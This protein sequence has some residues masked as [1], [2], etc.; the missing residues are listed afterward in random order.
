MTGIRRF[1]AP[2][3]VF[4]VLGAACT[5]GGKT[6]AASGTARP[7]T[8]TPTPVVPVSAEPGVFVYQNAGLT[9]TLHLTGDTGTLEIANETGRE[10]APPGFYLLDA[11]D[12]RRVDGTVTDAKPT[13]NDATTTFDVRFSGLQV[14]NVGLAVLVMGSDNFGAFV[15]Q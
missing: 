6:P 3:L 8:S 13:P 2:M 5:G 10:L 14:W 15:R 1:V 9:A 4:G 12:G 11:R 7:T